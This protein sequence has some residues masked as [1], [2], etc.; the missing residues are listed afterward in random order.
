M[1]VWNYH[2]DKIAIERS[3]LM[4]NITVREFN[5]EKTLSS[6][7]ESSFEVCDELDDVVIDDT[8]LEKTMPIDSVQITSGKVCNV[9][10]TPIATNEQ[11]PTVR[12]SSCNRK[13]KTT[14][15]TEKLAATITCDGKDYNISKHLLSK[16]I[17]NLDTLTNDEIED[18]LLLQML[19]VISDRSVVKLVLK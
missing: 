2:I 12:C 11:L 19:A 8:D 5:N 15:F 16:C 3:Y 14:S 9:C 13:F 4:K 6:N 18:Q 1:V 7:P 10:N 17:P